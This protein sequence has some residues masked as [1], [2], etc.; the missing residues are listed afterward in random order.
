MV[1]LDVEALQKSLV[2][3]EAASGPLP[4]TALPT[5]RLEEMAAAAAEIAECYRVLTK[6][7]S[8]VVGEL[9]RGQGTFTEWNHYPKGDV[10]D[11]DTHAQYYYHAHKQ[12]LRGTEHGHFHTFVR[13][14]GMPETMCP[15]D[16]PESV[17]RPIG[18]DALSHIIGISMDNAGY[19]FRIFTTNRWV[20]GE[21]WYKADDVCRLIDL[22]V[23][24][25]AVP[26]W[27]A[28]RWVTAMLRLFRPQIEWLL[29]ER[30][31]AAQVWQAGNPDAVVYED[32]KFE[33]PSV[34]D[35]SVDDQARLVQQALEQRSETT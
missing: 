26:S 9:L 10:Y 5:E 13:V 7:G 8:N 15:V 24:D 28:N 32:R 29:K 4:P 20:T 6:G 16:M 30:D 11:R 2:R 18:K 35:I 1:N 33:V 23:I 21:S 17:K 34:A 12:G 19:P 22:F 3:R 31:D 25:H 14:K 27:P